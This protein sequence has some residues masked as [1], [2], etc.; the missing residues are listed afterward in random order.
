M[1]LLYQKCMGKNLDLVRTIFRK[2][3]EEMVQLMQ[4]LDFNPKFS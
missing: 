2:F 1:H 3:G 4:F